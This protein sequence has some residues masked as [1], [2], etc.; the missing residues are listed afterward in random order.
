MKT[1]DFVE[2]P[3]DDREIPRFARRMLKRARRTTF[4]RRPGSPRDG[5]TRHGKG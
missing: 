5:R 2:N 4:A 1:D 3:V